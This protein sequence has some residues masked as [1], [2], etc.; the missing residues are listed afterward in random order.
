M[1]SS[2]TENL[3]VLVIL[4]KIIVLVVCSCN[5]CRH[6]FWQ[7]YSIQAVAAAAA[8]FVNVENHCITPCPYYS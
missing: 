8:W 2:L 5:I 6:N 4:F 3:A 1:A 7:T